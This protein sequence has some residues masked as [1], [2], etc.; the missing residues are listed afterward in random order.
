MDREKRVYDT[1]LKILSI[2]VLVAIW[3]W[4]SNG[5][6]KLFPTPAATFERLIKLIEKPIMKV[7]IL[8][9]IGISLRRVMLAL[10]AATVLGTGFVRRMPV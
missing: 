6:P 8:G 5:H 2:M 7:S 1:A 10:I 9:H 4:Y 3:I